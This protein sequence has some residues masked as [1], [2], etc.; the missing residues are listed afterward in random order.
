MAQ[1][2]RQ[3]DAG[4]RAGSDEP[5]RSRAGRYQDMGDDW[6]VRVSAGVAK[7]DRAALGELYEAWF[8]KAYSTARRATGGRGESLCMDVVQEAFVR[9]IRSMRAVRSE[10]QLAAWMKRVVTSAAYDMLRKEMRLARREREGAR[11][12]MEGGEAETV[13]GE[14]VEW[15]REELARLGVEEREILELRHRFGMTLR[16]VG[17]RL[18]LGA[19]AVDRRVTRV[20][21]AMRERGGE[22]FDE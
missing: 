12:E 3:P 22:V 19:G 14:Q 11:G 18:G 10:A 7:G 21:E 2:D 4:G 6:A 15:L 8:D 20:V 17:E 9:V 13:S 1:R 16:E 5:A